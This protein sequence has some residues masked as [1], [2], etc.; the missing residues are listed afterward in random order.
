MEGLS[1]RHPLDVAYTLVET[2]SAIT[3]LI[4][5]GGYVPGPVANKGHASSPERGNN[6]LPFLTGRQ[7][8]SGVGVDD[9]HKEI[10]VVQME[11]V[12]LRALDRIGKS[13]LCH[14]PLP[15][16]LASPDTLYLLPHG[17]GKG[18]G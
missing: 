1:G 17:G 15:E 16:S 13:Q 2:R 18:F 8:F 12:L 11:T 10:R 4:D 9:L 7:L 6:K 5:K 14:T 3:G